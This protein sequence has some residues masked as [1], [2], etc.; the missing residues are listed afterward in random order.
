VT[1][2][3]VRTRRPQE[4]A[5]PVRRRAAELI[6]R[7]TGLPADAG[8]DELYRAAVR[9]GLPEDEAAAVMGGGAAGDSGILA[10]GRALA[11]LS[12]GDA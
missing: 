5:E 11:H 7:R 3:L 9:L 1:G 10:A 8:A 6:A 12:G 4:A 2:S